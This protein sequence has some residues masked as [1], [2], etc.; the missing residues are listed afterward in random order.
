[1][2]LRNFIVDA[3]GAH[4]EGNASVSSAAQ[5]HLE[6]MFQ[7]LQLADALAALTPRPIPWNATLAGDVMLDT[8]PGWT[9]VDL[10]AKSAVIPASALPAITGEVAFHYNQRSGNLRFEN[11]RLATGFTSVDFSGVPGESLDVRARTTNLADVLPTLHL[12]DIKIP[13]PL[14]LQ[15]NG[16]EISL[17][18]TVTGGVNNAAFRGD[19][20]LTKASVLD[21]AFDRFSA[22]LDANTREISLQG[23]DLQRG[24]TQIQGDATLTARSGGF[25]DGAV[26]ARLEIR[27]A[28][29]P[30]LMKEARFRTELRGAVTSAAA[31]IS[32]TLSKP[33]ADVTLDIL[34]AA[35]FGEEVDRLRGILHYANGSV[36]FTNG[37]ATF[38]AGR[39]A[40]SG[41]YQ[42]T[43]A[44]TGAP[45]WTRGELAL[46]VNAQAIDAV[47]V[48]KLRAIAPG[49]QGK[50][51]GKFTVHGHVEP[52]DFQVHE[53]NGQG[54]ASRLAVSSEPLGDVTLTA[55]THGM[56]LSLHANAKI[57]AASMEGQGT[58]K[59][60]GD[61][62][63]PLRLRFRD[64]TVA[65]AARPH[66]DRG[67]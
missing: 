32:G 30:E 22:Q 29:I 17:A 3:M 63:A 28:S 40:F 23:I 6:G 25:D 58:W 7:Q 45:D 33:E 27:N 51:A 65:S 35:A 4:F 67:Q 59:L 39:I 37:D 10:D 9:G 16:G 36:R 26:A 50:F 5:L 1:M 43:A 20:S 13:Q 12:L 66:H 11:S 24:L 61:I 31:R 62:P 15:L 44:G 18:G 21:H 49:L 64:L 55:E 53:L 47:R 14:P 57:R 60:Q 2:T 46:D 8:E 52:G 19:V 42:G 56:D 38:G 54:S 34:H 48:A 41:S